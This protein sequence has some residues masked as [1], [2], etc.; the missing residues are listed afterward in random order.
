MNDFTRLVV[1]SPKADSDPDVEKEIVSELEEELETEA[2]AYASAAETSR[3]LP[4]LSWFFVLGKTAGSMSKYGLYAGVQA[5]SVPA[6]YVVEL[7]WG[8]WSKTL[9]SFVP[10]TRGQGWSFLGLGSFIGGP[11]GR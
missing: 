5:M 6:N 11:F 7:Y 2:P 4:R 1:M 8:E 10:K 9:F 3:R